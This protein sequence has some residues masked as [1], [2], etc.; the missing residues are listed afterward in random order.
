MNGRAP[1]LGTSA[2]GFGWVEIPEP[3]A[4]VMETRIVPPDRRVNWT[5][6]FLG[7]FIGAIAGGL[8]ARFGVSASAWPL[9]SPVGVFL[10]VGIPFG[11]AGFF[12][13][14]WYLTQTRLT[15][16]LTRIHKLSASAGMLWIE[17]TGSRSHWI[18]LEG[19]RLSDSP[20]AG[21]WYSVT[22]LGRG[23]RL[24]VFYIPGS[25]ASRLRPLLPPDQA[26]P[27]LGMG[28]S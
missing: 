21:D 10:T 25:V 11:I 15:P 26:L 9:N 1:L 23:R 22:F 4:T 17:S 18:S 16:T 28:R 7:F 3:P 12:V 6:G 2:T 5:A 20:V 19:M 8:A 14:R 27:I 24:S 13:E